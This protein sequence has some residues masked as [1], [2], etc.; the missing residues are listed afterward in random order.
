MDNDWTGG[1]QMANR[2]DA[3]LTIRLPSELL[4]AALEKSQRADVP[5]SQYLRHCLRRWISEDPPDSKEEE[6]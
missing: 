3:K 6:D 5:V 1:R 2:K 4:E